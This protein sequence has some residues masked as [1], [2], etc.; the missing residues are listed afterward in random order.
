MVQSPNTGFIRNRAKG[1]GDVTWLSPL[2]HSSPSHAWQFCSCLKR[3]LQ[4]RPQPSPMQGDTQNTHDSSSHMGT[5]VHHLNGFH[6]K[7]GCHHPLLSWS[8]STQHPSPGGTTSIG[9]EI[10]QRSQSP[11]QITRTTRLLRKQD[12]KMISTP[13]TT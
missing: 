5:A 9:S 11:H 12:V 8:T 6:P 4:A 7:C 10:S 2:H 1:D 13:K 3:S